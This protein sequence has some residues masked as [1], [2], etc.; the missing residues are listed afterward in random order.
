MAVKKKSTKKK[1][2]DVGEIMR[3]KAKEDHAKPRLKAVAERVK[4]CHFLSQE[5]E[6]LL[7]SR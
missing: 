1:D 5:M 3:V 2:P 6:L 7:R 4:Q